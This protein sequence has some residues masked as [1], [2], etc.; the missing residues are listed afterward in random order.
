MD[1]H[2]ERFED[3]SVLVFKGDALVAV[4]PAHRENKE[5]RSHWG[6]TYGGVLWDPNL[7]DTELDSIFQLFKGYLREQGFMKFYIK[8]IPSIY[9]QPDAFTMNQKL[10]GQ[11]YIAHTERVLA[12]DYSKPFQIHKTKLKHYRRGKRLGFEINCTTDFSRFWKEVLSPRLA[13]R[14]KV[15]PV[16]SLEEITLLAKR[17][18]EE[19]KQ[20]NIQLNGEILAGITLFDKGSV[21]K[22]QYGATTDLGETYRALEFL[23]IELI[24]DYKKQGKRFF[25]MGTVGDQRFP[26]GFN[27]GLKRQKEELGCI[28]FQQHF[29]T[30]D[31]K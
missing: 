1:Y 21:V 27:P 13:S 31:L 24:K 11:A 12:V 30:F 29:Y 17:F 8:E 23:F 10:Y 25:S 28:E 2:S 15:K 14:H 16:H 7:N 20:Y 4:C 18:P 19:I 26:E 22:S 5:L 9:L 6:L 3:H